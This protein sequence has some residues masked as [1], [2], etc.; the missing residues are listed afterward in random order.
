[1]TK[2]QSAYSALSG[3]CRCTRARSLVGGVAV[4]TALRLEL[5]D[6]VVDVRQA[7]VDARLVE[8][9][10]EH[11]HLE[12]AHE[13]ERELARHEAGA[14]DPDLRDLL[15]ER[16]V[17]GAHGALGALLHEVEGV[18]GCRELVAA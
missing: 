17:G 11:G 9:G 2:S 7:L 1:M 12:P 4:E 14:D 16:L 3:A 8:I 18:H 5:A 15:R 10:D 6:L 13:Q